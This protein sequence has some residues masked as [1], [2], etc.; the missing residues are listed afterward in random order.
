M[1][2]LTRGRKRVTRRQFLAQT[3]RGAG[4]ATFVVAGFAPVATQA[5]QRKNVSRK[6]ASRKRAGRRK[7]G[8]GSGPP[9]VAEVMVF[10]DEAEYTDAAGEAFVF[11]DFDPGPTEPAFVDGGSFSPEIL[12]SSP[13]AFDPSKVLYLGG[14]GDGIITDA[15]STTAANGVG[16]IAG[17]FTTPVAAFGFELLSIEGTPSTLHLFDSE[18]G[19]IDSIPGPPGSGFFGV[20]SGKAI[21]SWELENGILVT[22]NPDRYILDNFRSA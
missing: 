6:K 3:A 9:D 1:R 15:G 14:D 8:G 16:P 13:E 17:T 19:W 5:Q 11:L 18:D 22:G 2:R 20:V 12:F 4:A 7:A 21:A 10:F